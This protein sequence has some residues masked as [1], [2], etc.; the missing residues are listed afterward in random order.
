MGDPRPIGV[1]DSGLGGLTVVRAILDDLPHESIRYFGDNGRFPYGP[2][3]LSEIREFALQITQHLLAGDV[4]MIVVACNAATSAALPEVTALAAPVP[5]VG[6]IEPAVRAAVR[7]TRNGRVGLIGTRATVDSGAYLAS[8]DR[9]GPDVHVV[10]Q[11][12]P[13]FVEFVENGDTTSP[14][15]LRVAQEYLAPVQREDVDTIILGCTHYPFLRAAIH[16][17]VGAD[18]LLLSSAEETANDVYQVL[19]ERD[20]LA[21]AGTVPAH[22]FETSGDPDWFAALGARFLGPEVGTAD[23]VVLEPAGSA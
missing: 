14:E 11:A 9:V 19:A 16:L 8:F 2:R 12:C 20:L 17:V 4:K 22:R 3:P 5:V 1:F 6:V 21:E 18:V 10:S 7:A 13:R 23:R 15:L